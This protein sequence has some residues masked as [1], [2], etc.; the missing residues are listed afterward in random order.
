M[1]DDPRI[2][3][4]RVNWNE[5]TPVHAAADFYDVASFKAGRITLNPFEL[6]AVGDVQG[7]SGRPLRSPVLTNPRRALNEHRRRRA[8]RA[9]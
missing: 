6:A 2:A 9:R 8:L 7:K 1:T 4:N 5:R 3:K